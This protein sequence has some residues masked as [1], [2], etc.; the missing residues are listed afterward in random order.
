MVRATHAKNTAIL[1][2][3]TA[4]PSVTR[5]ILLTT[6]KGAL[7]VVTPSVRS[8]M[9]LMRIP[10]PVVLKVALQQYF[11]STKSCMGE[12]LSAGSLYQIQTLSDHKIYSTSTCIS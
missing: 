2:T 6:A 5:C 12:Y 3:I 1:I 8:V 10:I 11:A 7:P 9:G 4:V